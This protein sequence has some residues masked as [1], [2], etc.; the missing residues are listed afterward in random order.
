MAANVILS[1]IEADILIEKTALR[2]AEIFFSK[3]EPQQTEK[4]LL[5]RPETAE[6][7]Q[8]KSATL[9]RWT[10]NGKLKQY[11]I[12]G[13]VYYKRSEVLDAVKPLK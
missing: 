5:T 7:L 1:Q 13:R 3:F 6:L 2:T 9:N 4:E 12:G 10:I 11:G 8:V